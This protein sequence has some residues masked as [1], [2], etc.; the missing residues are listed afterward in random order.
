MNLKKLSKLF[1]KKLTSLGAV[2]T[3]WD[4]MEPEESAMVQSLNSRSAGGFW[5][6]FLIVMKEGAEKFMEKFYSN[7]GHKSI[8]DCGSTTG[9]FDGVSMLAAKEI[10]NWWAYKGQ[11]TSTRYIDVTGLGFLDPVGTPESKAIM[12]RW[13]DFYKRALDPTIAHLKTIRPRK[14]DGDKPEDESKYNTMIEK[15]AYDVLGA[16]LPAGTKT[17]ASCHMDL[18]QWDDK[19]AWMIYHPVS[20]IAEIAKTTMEVLIE[21]YPSTFIKKKVYEKSED[22]RNWAEKS[23]AY[24]MPREQYAEFT[25][26]MQSGMH[27]HKNFQHDTVMNFDYRKILEERPEK[28]ELPKIINEVGGYKLYFPIDFRSHRDLQRQRSALQ[29]VPLLTTKFG[30]EK[31]YLDQ[32]PE[33]VFAEAMILFDEQEKAIAALPCEETVKQYYIAMGYKVFDEFT[34]SL[35]DLI[36]IIELRTPTTVHPTARKVALLAYQRLK[37]VLPDY[38][39]IYADTSTDDFDIKRADQDLFLGDKRIS[40]I[41]K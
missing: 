32:L 15:R 39:K 25:Y 12:E 5:K 1:T 36:Y 21:R 26:A 41:E 22:Y 27:F 10:Q 37:E 18:R 23:I 7:Y 13:F 29:R 16:F 20:E 24:M 6:N 31:W 40:E 17:N 11:E 4:E 14:T 3:F 28:T 2:V 30:F 33:S 9:A 34:V 19:L 8:A 38:V 35:A